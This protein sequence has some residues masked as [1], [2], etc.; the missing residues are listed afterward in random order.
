M[1]AELITTDPNGV[2]TTT[3]IE[4]RR[5]P[6]R[7]PAFKRGSKQAKEQ[8]GKPKK[9]PAPRR[10]AREQ[11]RK[12]LHALVKVAMATKG[13]DFGNVKIAYELLLKDEAAQLER[14]ELA[15]AA[16]VAVR[17]RGM[18]R[19]LVGRAPRRRSAFY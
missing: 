9:K 10:T 14:E 17:G 19:G 12:R 1:K 4:T 2:T 18:R 7:R 8:A 13:L 11:L 3:E 16:S 15:K 6:G 5:K